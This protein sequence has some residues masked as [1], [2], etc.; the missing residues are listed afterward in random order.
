MPPGGIAPH[1][2]LF[3]S[4]RF[5][6]AVD[7]AFSLCLRLLADQLQERSGRPVTLEPAAPIAGT[8]AVLA[9]G[10]AGGRTLAAAL[11]FIV[12]PEGDDPWYTAKAALEQRL[13]SRVDGGCLV[14]I[15]QGVDLPEREPLTS[16]IVLGA[17]EML[18]RFVP[19]GHGDIRFPVSIRIRR[20]DEE[21]SYVTA[22]GGLASSW[23]RFTGR[24][25]GHFQLDSGALHRLPPGEGHLSE[26][27]ER[28]V[29]VA[30]GLSVGAA[31]E[32]AADD[33]WAAQRLTGGDG[34]ALI[35]EPP[36]AELSSGAGLRKGLR[37]TVQALRGPLLDTGAAARV[38]CFVGPYTSMD[39]QPVATALLGFDPS[40]YQGIDLICLAAE[41]TVKPL[42]NLTRSPILR[43]E[44]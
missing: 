14:W 17:E 4:E 43:S 9:Q 22:R 31:A 16:E 27:I 24:V 38:V 21:G 12:P 11:A 28:I 13:T 44:E 5:V 6:T 2:S 40:L 35:G 42:L 41:G 34:V 19:G 1:L 3:A 39:E 25:F 8:S 29:T 20:S 37:R 33:G 18:R 15:P 10:E 23:A 36:G 30:N 7:R 26:L 32:V